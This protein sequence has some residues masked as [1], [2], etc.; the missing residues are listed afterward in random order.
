MYYE[1]DAYAMGFLGVLAVMGL[2]IL[3]VAVASYV[4]YAIGLSKVMAAKGMDDRYRAWIPFWNAYVGGSIIEE[5]AGYEAFVIDG[6]KWIL[7]LGGVAGGILSGVIPIIG[8]VIPLAYYVYTIMCNAVL[9]KKYGTMT[10]MIITSIIGLPGIGYI[11]LSNQMDGVCEPFTGEYTGTSQ[12]TNQNFDAGSY[13]STSYGNG[14]PE[15]V[16]FETVEKEEV[17]A[18]DVQAPSYNVGGN[19]EED[20]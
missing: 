7:T 18:E 9:A 11:I 2:F 16:D 17:K 15:D 6:T 19:D 1:N 20:K 12:G 5:E 13:A 10:S 3:V 14:K 4:I 8:G